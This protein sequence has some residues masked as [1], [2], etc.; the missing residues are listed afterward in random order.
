MR[1][2]CA[3]TLGA[4]CQRPQWKVP[5]ADLEVWFDLCSPSTASPVS[6]HWVMGGGGADGQQ[7]LLTTE[8]RVQCKRP[9]VIPR[10]QLLLHPWQ[11]EPPLPDLVRIDLTNHHPQY[12]PSPTGWSVCK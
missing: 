8:S 5:K 12:L 7:V 2:I 6:S 11:I 1:E 3:E 4:A 10:V 9:I